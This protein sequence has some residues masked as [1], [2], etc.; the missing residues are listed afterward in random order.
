MNRFESTM[1]RV[2]GW[3]LVVAVGVV[4]SISPSQARAVCGDC[5]VDGVEECDDCNGVDGD[6]C[7]NACADAACGDDIVQVGVEE[8]DDGNV[9][10]E[11]SCDTFCLLTCGNGLLD[12]DEECDDG[13][14]VN[15]DECT[16][17]CLDADCG[18]GIVQIGVEECDDGNGVD[19]DS[20]DSFCEL[21]CGNG[22]V[23]AGEECDDGNDDDE[24][25]CDSD[26]LLTCG[27]GFLD[28]NEDC[29]DGNRIDSDE[30]TNACT[31][32]ECGD[33]ILQTGVEECD[34]GNDVDED[35]CDTFCEST[36]GNGFVDAGEDCDDGNT[37]D[38]DVCP[39][40][41][42]FPCPNS[43]CT[44]LG[45][46]GRFAAV[47]KKWITAKTGRFSEDGFTEYVSTS[48]A[49][50]LCAPA[51]NFAAR[52]SPTEI[53]GDVIL[54]RNGANGSAAG[55]FVGFY[56]DGDFEPG[57]YIAGDL[58]S[59]G[60]AIV[61][62]QAVVVDGEMMLDGTD[63]RLAGCTAAVNGV[64]TASNTLKALTPTQ[65]LDAIVIEN[66][67]TYTLNV[68][69]GVQVIQVNAIK[70]L[71][72]KIDGEPVPAR[73]AIQCAVDTEVVVVNIA[74]EFKVGVGSAVTSNCL[75][76]KVIL[77]IHG[78]KAKISLKSGAQVTP[79]MLTPT[80]SVNVPI[81]GAVSNVYSGGKVSLAGAQVD[82][83]LR[84][85]E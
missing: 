76:D 22:V 77:N 10:D 6:V 40:T 41:C 34:D 84:C 29:D 56:L 30:C 44:C 50:G 80:K 69:S 62:P 18:D 54:S 43:L 67:G 28:G 38:G 53:D 17:A 26:C 36:C 7:T 4:V 8:C 82:D 68:G 81:L 37:L 83:V 47:A 74:N 13:N 39:S 66:G 79:V 11:D 31:D 32:A 19:G 5:T 35:G 2:R 51:G 71:S 3:L 72:T 73:L 78:A 63:S 25:S 59:G 21:P 55:V 49:G 9:D 85:G 75:E 60:G 58:V 45:E 1:V 48:V 52:E 20:C 42:H 61:G 27:N 15:S 23:D 46:A 12:G 65:T 16:N 57:T 33:G 64:S 70:V 24:D 14:Q